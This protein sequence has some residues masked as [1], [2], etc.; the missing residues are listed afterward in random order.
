MGLFKSKN[1]TD[2]QK[3]NENLTKTVEQLTYAV[4]SSYL[5]EAFTKGK[6]RK[7]EKIKEKIEKNEL[8]INILKFDKIKKV[9]KDKESPA[10]YKYLILNEKNE[11]NIINSKKK[12][13]VKAINT[14]RDYKLKSHKTNI[15]RFTKKIEDLNTKIKDVTN[16]E[17]KT[18][19]ENAKKV[20]SSILVNGG[21]GALHPSKSD[22]KKTS[23]LNLSAEEMTKLS[24]LDLTKIDTLIGVQKDI[25]K[26]LTKIEENMIK[27]QDTSIKTS[28]IKKDTNKI[29]E[30]SQTD[31]KK[32]KK[33]GI[34]D[35]ITGLISTYLLTKGKKLLKTLLRPFTKRLD[36]I[37]ESFGKKL[38][39]VKGFFSRRLDSVKKF[40]EPLTDRLSQLS[41]KVNGF[42][43]R[44]LDKIKNSKV[45]KFA[46]K[47]KD[48]II[49]AKEKV[50]K[51]AGKVKDKIITAKEK[52]GR[53]VGKVK[54]KF[55]NAK[56]KVGGFFRNMWDTGK[57]KASNL[58][59][60][61]KE[62][63]KTGWKNARSYASK[64]GHFVA[65]KAEQYGG[66]VYNI[67]RKSVKGVVQF[68]KEKIIQ[69]GG[70]FL[71]LAKKKVQPI[72]EKIGIKAIGKAGF[73]QFANKLPGIGILAGLGFG[74]YDL[75]QGKPKKAALDILAGVIPTVLDAAGAL[76]GP[77]APLVVAAGLAA[78]TGLS[79]YADSLDNKDKKVTNIK[80]KH[81]K[82]DSESETKKKSS[83][84]RK[85]PISEKATNYLK[86]KKA[87]DDFNKNNPQTEENS[88][89]KHDP[90]GFSDYTVYKNKELETKSK[91]LNKKYYEAREAYIK[92]RQHDN[93][94]KSGESYNR[95]SISMSKEEAN[96]FDKK[97]K[98]MNFDEKNS[99]AERTLEED[100]KK[101]QKKESKSKK[102]SAEK[103]K[104]DFKI[105]KS[106]NSTKDRL[107]DAVKIGTGNTT[108]M[109]LGKGPNKDI[110]VVYRYNKQ[111]PF[112]WTEN[113]V[114]KMA[115]DIN[116]GKE[117][118]QGTSYI[119]KDEEHTNPYSETKAEVN[120]EPKM[121]QKEESMNNIVKLSP[122]QTKPIVINQ[123]S[124]NRDSV[125]GFG[126]NYDNTV[127][128]AEVFKG[129]AEI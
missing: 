7:A 105:E 98:N 70:E 32:E 3:E 11:I 50:G 21:L 17:T 81:T 84:M 76:S 19:E 69:Y 123:P 110:D 45:G 112:I 115:Q 83:K 91:L 51:F 97:S 6:K 14:L 60:S 128:L 114:V 44:M 73:K 127:K 101:Y 31:D 41:E 22:P 37:R 5:P 56:E 43:D 85:I 2:L 113:D 35:W 1:I 38:D 121:L 107:R 129:P 26:R 68:G 42:K 118:S 39:S 20:N 65:E 111:Q 75:I 29:S 27:E 87:L 48:K 54:D 72:I 9:P 126:Y 52:V 63:A 71:E 125:N 16:K 96:A 99:L 23:M 109:Y 78:S 79:V 93:L 33:G 53:V 104:E 58:L 40:F 100:A 122:S 82:I 120:K 80:T 57:Q 62:T 15:V 103:P 24:T 28:A 25:L 88:E 116:D 10:Y 117:V 95:F 64:A 18:D 46:G 8:K 67:A 119:P 102:T 89:V 94:E 59:E 34:L 108:D 55:V 49:T 47:V 106:S 74:A 61:A 12:S 124:E 4:E 13:H 66:K 86:A 90:T 77:F 92:S 36:K 30:I